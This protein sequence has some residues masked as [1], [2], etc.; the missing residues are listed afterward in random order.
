MIKSCRFRK[1]TL[2]SGVGSKQMLTAESERSRIYRNVIDQSL[3]RKHIGTRRVGLFRKGAVR[4][5]RRLR[6]NVE[7]AINSIRRGKSWWSRQAGSVQRARC[8]KIARAQ[9]SVNGPPTLKVHNAGLLRVAGEIVEC[10]II[11]SFSQNLARK[12]EST[13]RTD[14]EKKIESGKGRQMEKVEESGKSKTG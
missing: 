7:D 10:I 11:R 12:K 1:T 13:R 4:L 5:N 2:K 6:R 14:T 9:D 3:Q 8:C